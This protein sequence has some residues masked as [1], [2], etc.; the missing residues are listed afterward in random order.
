MPNTA[1]KMIIFFRII[2]IESLKEQHLFEMQ[3]FYNII[4]VFTSTFDQFNVS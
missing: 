1:V 2:W 3:I 4:N